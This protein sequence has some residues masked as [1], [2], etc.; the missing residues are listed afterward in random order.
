MVNWE[1]ACLEVVGVLFVVMGSEQRVDVER[2]A[3]EK[4]T[5]A[6]AKS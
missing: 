4:E 6:Q 3:E 1:A 5:C 2:V